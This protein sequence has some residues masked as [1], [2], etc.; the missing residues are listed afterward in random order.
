MGGSG[1][2]LPAAEFVI[3]LAEHEQGMLRTKDGVVI[4]FVLS[5]ELFQSY[6]KLAYH[7]AKRRH[8][9]LN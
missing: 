2:H 7:P 6:L 5:D 9:P 8:R 4:R 3:E 1:E